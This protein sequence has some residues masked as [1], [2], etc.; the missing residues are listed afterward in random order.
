MDKVVLKKVTSYDV[1]LIKKALENAVEE[2]GGLHKYM[3][4]GDKVMLKLNLLMK[5]KPEEATTTHPSFVEA[6]VLVLQDFGATVILA[7]SPGGPFTESRLKGIYEAGGY[8][9]VANK[10]GAILN[11]DVSE[12]KRECKEAKY[13]KSQRII[14]ALDTVDHVISVS[15]LKTHGMMRFT[16][17]VKN[18]FGIVPGILKAEYHFTMPKTEDF[19]D[20][21]IDICLCANPVLSFMD[22]IVGME[23]DGPS[24]G[25]PVEIGAVLVSESP[26][27]LDVIATQIVGIEPMSVPTI[28]QSV[29]RQ[30]IQGDFSDIVLVGEKLE[31]FTLEKF[32]VPE[33]RGV[34]FL[35]KIPNWLRKPMGGLLQTK[36]VFN[37][38]TCIGC[39]ECASSCPPKVIDM[40]DRLPYVHLEGCIRCFCCQELC[41]AKAVDIHRSWLMK[42]LLDL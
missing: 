2:L 7:D 22:G 9:E 20:A 27:H 12:S 14:H 29:K 32:D 18:L 3:S 6:L 5:K 30:L 24:A 36:P 33:I 31:A 38:S 11:Y 15:K 21:L 8:Q 19:A 17:A 16:G 39:G 13:L 41:P 10:T 1:A 37:H 23:G 40:K 4:P 26:Y 28:A 25:T 35:E 42:R 34:G